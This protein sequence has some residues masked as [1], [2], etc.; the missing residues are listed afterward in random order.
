MGIR[1]LRRTAHRPDSNTRKISLLVACLAVS[2]G[3]EAMASDVTAPLL[4]PSATATY[5][6]S[7]CYAGVN[8]G[9]LFSAEQ[10]SLAM[11]GGFLLNNNLFSNPANKSQVGHSFASDGT[12]FTGGG[13]IGCNRQTGMLVW[14]FEADFD[15]AGQLS[16]TANFGPAGP[17][18]GASDPARNHV[19]SQ[20]DSVGQNGD[21]YSTVRG[22]IGL[23]ATPTLLLYA[24]GG[25]AVARISSSANVSFGADRLFL[26]NN[27]F[28][29]SH[30]ETRMGWTI[31]AGSEWAFLPNWSVRAEYL[32]MDFGSFSYALACTVPSCSGAPTIPYAWSAHVQSADHVFRVGLN[33]TFH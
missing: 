31:G 13:Q 7:G 22:R 16:K 9:A 4:P 11:A 1:M 6:W 23:A 20:T 10:Y 18:I 2:F 29:G 14:G 27:M 21:W 8:A 26:S 32:F 5:D 12:S 3:S 33:Y 28:A 25:L 17:I 15:H 19:S 24:T 30:S